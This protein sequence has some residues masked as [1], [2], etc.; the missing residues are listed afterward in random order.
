MSTWRET[1]GLDNLS[2]REWPRVMSQRKNAIE[3]LFPKSKEHSRVLEYLLK[4]LRASEREMSSFYSRWSVCERRAQAYIDLPEFER[5][6]KELNDQGKPPKV[7]AITVPYSFSTIST[8]VTY[9]LHTFTGRKPMF[10][11]GSHKAETEEAARM[12]EIM[13]QYNADHTRLIQTHNQVFWDIQ[14]Y[15]VGI[16]RTLWKEEY[17]KRPVIRQAPNSILGLSLPSITSPG[18]AQGTYRATEEQLVFQGTDVMPI[19]PFCFFPDPRV[20][21][22]RANTDGEFVFWRTLMGKHALLKAEARGEIKWVRDVTKHQPVSRYAEARHSELFGLYPRTGITTAGA[23]LEDH[24]QIDQGTIE[25]IPAELGLSDSEVP[26]KWLFTI[27]N[28]SQILQAEPFDALHGKHPVAVAEPYNVGYTFGG[29]SIAEYLA[30]M[31]DSMSW[32]INSHIF[33]VR[34]VL[35]NRYV[36]DPATIEM[37]DLKTG[38]PGG[39]IRTKPTAMGRDVRELITQLGVQDV[40]Q[41]HVKDAQLFMRMGDT[42]SSVSDNMRGIQSQGGRKTATEVR[43]S[44][45]A[46]ASRLASHTILISAQALVSLTE[47]MSINYQQYLSQPFYVQVTGMRGLEHPLVISP[48]MII[49]DFHYPI[50]DGTLP[51][52]RIAL[53]D[54]WEKIFVGVS[55]DPQLRANY[56]VGAIFEWI[57][58]LS[59]AKNLSRFKLTPDEQVQ[60]QAQAGNAV[61]INE[62]ISQL[63]Q[64]P[65]A[66]LLGG[67]YGPGGGM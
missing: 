37:Q 50:H 58:E 30:P 21:M 42:L 31:Q 3:V 15:G 11:V 33:N 49:G 7:T 10:Q 60:Q 54:V 17:R 53:L 41:G 27:A 62:A 52:D 66:R 22:Y 51:L 39:I 34:A 45:E 18:S 23:D 26:E 36:V 9:L 56:N 67:N 29:P 61:P 16:W 20:P 64:G 46:G 2:R 13:L 24:Y 25:L 65:G 43:T 8:I 32:F 55:Q 28:E 12:M 38:E 44:A 48:E 47:M 1:P 5:L 35:Q 63:G 4:R 57:A 40:T 6:I 19:D 14:L 59:G